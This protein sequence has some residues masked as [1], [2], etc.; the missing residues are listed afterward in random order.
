MSPEQANGSREADARS[1]IYAVGV[2]LYEA[3]TG[4]VPYQA[5]TLNQLLFKIVLEE[6]I[7]PEQYVSDLD[8]AFATIIKKAMARK[9]EHRFQTAAEFRQALDE[10][11]TT[12]AQVGVIAEAGASAHLLEAAGLAAPTSMGQALG[13]T[14]PAVSTP[15]VRTV[16]TWAQSQHDALPDPRKKRLL[17]AS[18]AGAFAVAAIAAVVMFTSREPA[19]AASAVSATAVAAAAP[20]PS[21]SSVPAAPAPAPVESANAAAPSALSASPQP[22]PAAVAP[23]GKSAKAGSKRASP[24]AKQPGD[25]PRAAATVAADDFG[26]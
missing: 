20:L 13:R 16:N 5:P 24:G 25:K 15:G 21:P 10:W 6:P 12:G 3:V 8:P 9:M 7:P 22:Q 14:T 2:I 17:I 1:D 4:N 26:Y 11:A 23:V 18:V 19:P